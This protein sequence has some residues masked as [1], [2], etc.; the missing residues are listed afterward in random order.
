MQAPADAKKDLLARVLTQGEAHAHDSD[1][2]ISRTQLYNFMRAVLVDADESMVERVMQS[3][4]DAVNNDGGANDGSKDEDV[5]ARDGT[6]EKRKD[7]GVTL[8]VYFSSLS[9]DDICAQMTV[10]LSF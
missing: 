6:D 7:V 10:D 1:T 8:G 9:E 2:R 3:V 5:N 4:C